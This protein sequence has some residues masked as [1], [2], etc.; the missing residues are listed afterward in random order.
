MHKTT[1][2]LLAIGLAASCLLATSTE[3][4][5]G[6]FLDD[7][8]ATYVGTTVIGWNVPNLPAFNA[9]YQVFDLP[10][11]WRPGKSLRVLNLSSTT[12]SANL[13]NRADEIE[14]ARSNNVGNFLAG[15]CSMFNI[16]PLFGSGSGEQ[17]SYFVQEWQPNCDWQQDIIQAFS[18]NG[19][20]ST[21]AS[22]T[23]VYFNSSG[24]PIAF[25]DVT[26]WQYPLPSTTPTLH[27]GH[28]VD[29]TS[30]SQY[31]NNITP[32]QVS[33]AIAPAYY[34]LRSF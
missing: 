30:T 32:G 20:S 11:Q 21:S 17:T 15:D 4:R 18:F 14:R 19:A 27:Y 22:C 10:I 16:S 13:V 12:N 31:Q 24:D 6:H 1:S 2:L 8:N 9:L 33:A 3:S 26:S 23:C 29:M 5:A 7:N 34:Q 25:F 28:R